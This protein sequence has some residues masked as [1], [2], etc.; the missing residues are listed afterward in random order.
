MMKADAMKN[1]FG[2]AVLIGLLGL[3]FMVLPGVSLGQV[4]GG[5]GPDDQGEGGLPRD[6]GSMMM[7]IQDGGF[8]AGVPVEVLHSGH[9]FALRGNDSFLLRLKV[10]SLQPLE[11]GQIQRLLQ[12]NK[13]LEEI[14]DDIRGQ[15]GDT[16]YRGSLILERSIYPLV[17]IRIEALGNNSTSLQADL[18]DGE[19]SGGNAGSEPPSETQGRVSV[20]IS[21]SDG[22]MMGKGELLL[23]AGPKAGKYALLLDMET[24]GH[25]KKMMMGR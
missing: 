7:P 15:E 14:R 5:D 1:N 23:S 12:S 6:D 4:N 9:G 18:S 2:R 3:L 11:A 24:K 22:G 16:V 8:P 13:S 10:E 19:G 25:G 20:L 17:N 21:P